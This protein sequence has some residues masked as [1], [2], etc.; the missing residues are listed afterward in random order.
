MAFSL[1]PYVRS[2]YNLYY[3]KVWAPKE[4]QWLKQIQPRVTQDAANGGEGDEADNNGVGQLGPREGDDNVFEVRIDGWDDWDSDTDE[5]D[6]AVAQQAINEAIAQADQQPQ[7][8]Q[9]ADAL[10]Q[11][12]QQQDQPPGPN[13]QNAQQAQQPQPQQ[14]QQPAERRLSF[15]PTAI[16]ETVLGAL[17]FPAIAGM[18]GELLKF[19]LP[20][21]W[22]TPARLY[23]VRPPVLQGLLQAKWGRS[24]IGGCLFVVLKDAVVLYVRWKMAQMHRRRRVVEWKDRRERAR[25]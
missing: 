20:R 19:W 18:S 1:L 25:A 13:Q 11:A 14:P 9:N 2:A 4:K 6:V 17:L 10:P 15:S 24:L 8:E 22:T 16:A 23:R 3:Q 21:S 7:Q 12:G 5:E